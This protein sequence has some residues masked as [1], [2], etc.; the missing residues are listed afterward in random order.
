MFRKDTLTMLE[1]LLNTYSEKFEENFPIFA[2]M[3][4]DEKEVCAMIAKCIETNT[5]Y[6]MKDDESIV[7]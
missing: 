3:G 7:Y 4:V 2:F 1:E 5:P 6:E